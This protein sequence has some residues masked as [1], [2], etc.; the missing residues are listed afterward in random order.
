[1]I[2]KLK[3]DIFFRRYAVYFT[4][5][6]IVAF[7]NYA[8]HPILG[9]LLSPADFGDVQAFLSLLTQITII[10]L[11]FSVVTVNITANIEDPQERDAVVT[12]LQKIL[13]RI[14]GVFL[15]LLLLSAS[16]ISSFFNFS[17]ISPI[18][19]LGIILLIATKTIFPSAYLQG[20]GRFAE[21]SLSGIIFSFGRLIFAVIFI[22][23]GARVFGAVFGIVLSYLTL[24]AYLFYKTR[25]S[26]RLG[27][28][29]NVH[30]LEKGRIE[31]ELKYGMLVFFATGLVTIYYT[32]DILIIKHYF[33]PTE[34][35][36]YSGISAIAKILFF[37]IGPGATVLFSSIKI[38]QTFK[39]NCLAFKKSLLTSIIIGGIG[40]F[41]FYI[42][43]DIVVSIMIGAKYLPFAHFLPKAGV[44]MLLSALVNIFV[45]YF[46][47]LRRFFLIAISLLGA[48][49]M[50]FILLRGHTDIDE[51]LN[52]LILSL[53]AIIILLTLFY[54]KDYFNNRICV[55]TDK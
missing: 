35:G 3:T 50:G 44:V 23:L 51:I 28:K 6:M 43:S 17:T 22:L 13:F 54:A 41:I 12:E 5:S 39:E 38:R 15:V 49:S 30:V 31:K 14:V 27:A 24:F 20:S 1:M 11:A 46:L 47:A 8:F 26:F 42:F 45:Y 34:A 52:N 16:K 36:I 9:R 21:L 2:N 53:S 4:G 32:S 55:T 40:L 37:V 10:F 33:E 25:D 19:G 48:V 7:L 29:T 18:I